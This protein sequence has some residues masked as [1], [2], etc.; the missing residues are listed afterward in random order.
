MPADSQLDPTQNPSSTYYLH[1]S[2]HAGSKLVSTPF[3]GTGY[4]DWKR[5]MII[6]LTAKNK[7]S[8]IDGSLPQPDSTSSDFHAWTRCNNMLIGWL[9]SSMDRLTAKSV[10]Y[11]STAQE[12]WLDLEERYG[13]ASMAQLYSLQEQLTNMTQQSDQHIADYFTKMKTIWD[14]LDHLSPMPYCNCNGCTCGLTKQFLKLQQDQ[15]MMHFL[16]KVNDTFHQVRTNILM[17]EEPP[18]ISQAYRLLLQEQRHKALTQLANPLPEPM[19]FVS[20]RNRSYPKHSA[21]SS[22]KPPDRHNVSGIKRSSRYFCDHC[23]ISGHSIERCFKVHGYPPST[24]NG[25]RLAA[26]VHS[27]PTASS[28]SIEHTGLTPSQFKTL[29][30]LLGKQTKSDH[31]DCALESTTLD[32]SHTLAG[33]FDEKASDSW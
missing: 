23:Q 6:G 13:Q 3:D 21:S 26:L 33:P 4:S 27:S 8:F 14:E 11:C 28:P 1:P 2:D 15:R 31:D 30:S 12:I 24:K 29:V 10:M 16:M 18:S 20:E 5:S 19:A 25:K 7:M 17:M 22:Q 9:I 32:T